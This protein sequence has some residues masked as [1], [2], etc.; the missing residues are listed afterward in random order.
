MISSTRT[1][2]QYCSVC[3]AT[4]DMAVVDTVQEHEVTWLKCP[5]CNG[6]LPHMISREEPREAEVA[7]PAA[8]ETPAGIPELERTG[9][10]DYDPSLTFAVGEIVYHRSLNRYGRVIEKTVLPGQRAAL[11]VQ[12][13]DGESMTL[14]EGL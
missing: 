6:I 2:R 14:R 8:V 3:K 1:I 11:R 10:R 5:R 9:A 12:F 4:L 13:E 7:A